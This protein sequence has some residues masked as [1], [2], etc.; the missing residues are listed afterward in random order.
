[1]QEQQWKSNCRTVK[2]KKKKSLCN[3]TVWRIITCSFAFHP[4]SSLHFL[5][6]G[7]IFE[8]PSTEDHIQRKL[9]S[10]VSS[11]SKKDKL[12]FDA[13]KQILCVEIILN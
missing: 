12:F 4:H 6:A 2:K 9:Q 1:M 3:F 8:P 5:L 13:Q 10:T 7:S 11:R